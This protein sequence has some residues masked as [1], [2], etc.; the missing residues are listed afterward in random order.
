MDDL[1]QARADWL[2]AESRLTKLQHEYHELQRRMLELQM[3]LHCA[4]ARA[5]C[6]ESMHAGFLSGLMAGF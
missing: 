2:D 4:E 3:R 6:A 1:Q 5:Q